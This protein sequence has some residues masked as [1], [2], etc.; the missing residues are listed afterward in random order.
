MTQQTYI[1]KLLDWF[2]MTEAKHLPM[3]VNIHLQKVEKCNE[4]EFP[5]CELGGSIMY[6]VRSMRPDT[7]NIVSQLSHFLNFYDKTHWKAAK[8]VLCYLKKIILN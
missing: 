7:V 3:V 1:R 2:G 8:H 6:L 5:Y 4:V